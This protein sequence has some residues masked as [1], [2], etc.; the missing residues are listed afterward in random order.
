MFQPM[1]VLRLDNGR[2]RLSYPY[3]GIHKNLILFKSKELQCES[4]ER[5]ISFDLVALVF[6]L[7][8]VQVLANALLSIS[9]FFSTISLFFWTRKSQKSK[10]IN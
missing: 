7:E 6:V 10:I 4:K 3:E 2:G 5:H 9:H 1:V 8:L